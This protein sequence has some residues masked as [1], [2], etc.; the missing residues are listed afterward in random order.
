ML[1]MAPY[2]YYKY[3]DTI[4]ELIVYVISMNVLSMPDC[5]ISLL[6]ARIFMFDYLFVL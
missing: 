4:V 3:Y 5:R 6:F 2:I 1:E